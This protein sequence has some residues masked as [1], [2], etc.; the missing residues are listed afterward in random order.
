MVLTLYT[1]TCTQSNFF[2]FLKKD[3]FITLL[4]PEIIFNQVSQSNGELLK[5]TEAF[6]MFEFQVLFT[7]S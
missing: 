7:V 4:T 2:K 5:E 3:D 6:F 1:Y